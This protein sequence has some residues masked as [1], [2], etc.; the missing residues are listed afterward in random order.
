[1]KI[2][3]PLLLQYFTPEEL[4]EMKTIV[5]KLHLS[6]KKFSTIFHESKCKNGN[7]AKTTT[8]SVERESTSLRM[9]EK[10][11]G[12]NSTHDTTINAI[13]NEILLKIF[14]YLPFSDKLR[15]ASVCK[16]WNAIVYDPLNWN[17]LRF[18]EW[19]SSKDTNDTDICGRK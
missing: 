19:T 1:M 9:S 14:S 16:K 13:P 3:Q 5:I 4:A 17:M 10:S 8:T 6:Q 7:E 11:L 18:S 12:V 15:A 2:F